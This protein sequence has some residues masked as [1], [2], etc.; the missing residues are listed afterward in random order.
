MRALVIED[1]P[2][3]AKLIETALRTENIVFEP[4]DR[5]EDGIELAKLYDFDIILLDLRLPDIDGYEVVR[6]LR[7]AR[8]QTPILILS[9]RTD[10]TDKVRG[11][12]NGA[13]D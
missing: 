2:V 3:S 4:T 6:R 12:T 9:G 11:L 10:T 1:D 13:D 8:V 5:G 7:A